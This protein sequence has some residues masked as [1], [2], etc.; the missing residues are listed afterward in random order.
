M[1]YAKLVHHVPFFKTKT[2]K[3]SISISKKKIAWEREIHPHHTN[4]LPKQKEILKQKTQ[5]RQITLL[6]NSMT[7]TKLGEHGKN[8][9]TNEFSSSQKPFEILQV[10]F[11]KVTNMVTFSE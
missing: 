10:M 6:P 1:K 3:I 11:Y 8:I 4:T 2:G 5:E 7:K 9:P